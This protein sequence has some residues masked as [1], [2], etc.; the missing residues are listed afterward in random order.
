MVPILAE[1]SR[2]DCKINKKINN[3]NNNDNNNN[4]NKY[5]YKSLKVHISCYI[6]LSIKLSTLKEITLVKLQMYDETT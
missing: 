2:L 1:L 5:I 6:I 4:N 3:N